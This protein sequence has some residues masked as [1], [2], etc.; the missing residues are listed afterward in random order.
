MKWCEV[1]AKPAV[2][3]C[4]FCREVCLEYLAQ[5]NTSLIGGPGTIV[6]IDE[7]KF[8]KRKYNRGRL[9]DGKWVLGGIERG[10]DN[11]FL[12]VVARRDT[13]T[14]LSVIQRNVL[15]GTDIYTDEWAAYSSLSANGYQHGTVNHSYNFI[16]PATGVHTQNIESMWKHA[17]SKLKRGNGTSSSLFDSYLIE[18]IWRRKYDKGM[19]FANLINHISEVY[20]V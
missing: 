15:P 19:A 11:I 9:R 14:L 1:S 12:E 5:H 6:E 2:D 3:W 20:S 7:S 4:H 17:K 16:N 8:G 13:N 18:F 10:T